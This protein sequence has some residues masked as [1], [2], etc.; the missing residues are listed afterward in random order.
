VGHVLAFV[1]LAGGAQP[2][3]RLIRQVACVVTLHQPSAPFTHLK[4]HSRTIPCPQNPLFPFPFPPSHPAMQDCLAGLM[5]GERRAEAMDEEKRA[6]ATVRAVMRKLLTGTAPA[7][8]QCGG[9]RWVIVQL[10]AGNGAD[11][12][13]SAGS[14][15]LCPLLAPCP[16]ARCV[17]MRPRPPPPFP[18]PHPPPAL[19][20][21]LLTPHP[22]PPPT[23]WRSPGAP[24]LAGHRA[25]RR[26][27]REHPC[28]R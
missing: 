19:L 14:W 5:L 23:L 4:L 28:H 7:A 15:R 11:A 12:G 17:T 26:Q 16:A 13:T 1:G 8:A 25:P 3:L 22:S 2:A 10:A 24:A 21:F 9:V 27:A 6:A 20:C 18:P